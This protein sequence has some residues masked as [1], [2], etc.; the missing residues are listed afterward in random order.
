[1]IVKIDKVFF[2]GTEQDLKDRVIEICQIAAA[3]HYLDVDNVISEDFVNAIEKYAGDNY[4]SFIAEAMLKFSHEKSIRSYITTINFADYNREQRKCLLIKPSEILLENAAYEWGIYCNLVDYYVKGTKYKNVM[5]YLKRAIKLDMIEPAHLGGIYH[6]PTELS[7]KEHK[8]KNMY[9]HKACVVFDRDTTNN[10]DID[11]NKKEVFASLCNGIEFNKVDN[12]LVYRLNY[13]SEYVW[14]MW[15]KRAIENYFPKE[16]YE[17]SGVDM[18]T[19]DDQLPYDYLKF[20]EKNHSPKNY[21]KKKLKDIA[22][23]LSYDY[24]ESHTQHF[25]INGE[26]MSEIMLLLLK[27]AKIA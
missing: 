10:H 13:N 1:M 5:N 16:K 18:S 11:S 27:I 14:H 12:A 17:S 4:C 2:N 26:D 6:L 19:F 24:F 20:D 21:T 22:N 7:L 23:G 8:Y 15:Y 9:R 3:G 25:D